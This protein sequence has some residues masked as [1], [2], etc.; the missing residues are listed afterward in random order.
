[1]PY[2]EEDSTTIQS[3]SGYRNIEGPLSERAGMPVPHYYP[4]E[5]TMYPDM[6]EA[7]GAAI[8]RAAIQR[9]VPQGPSPYGFSDQQVGRR[10]SPPATNQDEWAETYRKTPVPEKTLASKTFDAL[11]SPSW[12]AIPGAGP[13]SKGIG[14][15][16]MMM[17]PK[18]KTAGKVADWFTGVD[19]RQ[20]FEVPDSKAELLTEK[21]P[22]FN[23]DAVVTGQEKPWYHIP[24]MEGEKKFD[25]KSRW[26]GM[27]DRKLKDTISHP[28]LFENYPHMADMPVKSI[29][30]SMSKGA[31]DPKTNTMRLNG[32]R[33]E[34][35]LS[36]VL[37]EVQHAIQE[38]EGFARGG[39]TNEFLPKSH[40]K[41]AARVSDEWYGIV[42]AMQKENPDFNEYTFKRAL[43][44]YKDKRELGPNESEQLWFGMG[45]P[46]GKR[47]AQL[48]E[49]KDAIDEVE[50]EAY[51]KYH[52][53]AGEVEARLVQDR[54]KK[55][56][57]STPPWESY[58]VAP[59]RQDVRFTSADGGSHD[60]K[61]KQGSQHV[62]EH[63]GISSSPVSWAKMLQR[64]WEIFNESSKN[65]EGDHLSKEE[66]M[67][68]MK[69][70]N[71]MPLG[72]DKTLEMK[73][74]RGSEN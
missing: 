12:D 58:D 64:R 67:A 43:K 30:I 34:D 10:V 42:Q 45:H 60:F 52:A 6:Q 31:Y 38:H 35:L 51:N 25:G 40:A 28:E 59:A 2:R 61:P 5:K 1:M 20:R 69:K 74:S 62:T 48:A 21:L 3:G 16:G 8:T 24:F 22:L 73:R 26:E 63:D 66:I 29:G 36:T 56:D 9:E 39:N 41:T 32:G 72:Y 17:G 70:Q 68:L 49:Q 50:T 65:A 18:A 57:Y 44:G 53:L 55:N 15:A 33:R 27:T 19:G 11:T 71:M 7:I 46:Q 14:L 4:F 47:L 23:K 13:M 54:H 37:H